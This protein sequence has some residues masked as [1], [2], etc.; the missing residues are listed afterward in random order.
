MQKGRSVVLVSLFFIVFFCL[1]VSAEAYEGDYFLNMYNVSYRLQHGTANMVLVGDSIVANIATPRIQYG[2]IRQWTP[3]RWRGVITTTSTGVTDQGTQT[4]NVPAGT[5]FSSNPGDVLA[6]GSIGWNPVPVNTYNITPDQAFGTTFLGQ[7]VA[8]SSYHVWR[9]VTGVDDWT[10][11]ANLTARFIYLSNLSSPRILL[12]FKLRNNTNLGGITADLNN[13]VKNIYWYDA[14]ATNNLTGTTVTG[15]F[16][17]SS[18]NGNFNETLFP[19]YQPFGTRIFRRDITTGLQVGTLATG[20]FTT[21]N[22]TNSSTPAYSDQGLQR[23]MLANELNTFFIWLG[24]NSAPDEW[25]GNN[26][27]NYQTN[28]EN[29]IRR[30]IQS[31]NNVSANYSVGASEKPFFVLVSTYDTANNNTKF[32]QQEQALYNISRHYNNISGIANLA[33]VAYLG[34]R[35]KLNVTNGSFVTWNITYLVDGT[36]PSYN[37]SNYTALLMWQEVQ[38]ALSTPNGSLSTFNWE[39]T[40]YKIKN[41]TLDTETNYFNNSGVLNSTLRLYN[42]SNALIFY[43]N[44]TGA[45]GL[46]VNANDGNINI[47]LQPNENLTVLYNFNLTEDVARNNSP[48]WFSAVST[49]SKSIASNLTSTINA[50]VIFNVSSCTID[51]ISYT[52]HTSAFTKTYTSSEYNCSSGQVT[53]NVSGLE[54]ASGSNT[55]AISYTAAASSGDSGSGTSSPAVSAGALSSTT[56][57]S[58]IFVS[59]NHR[60]LF[61]VKNQPH[62]LRVNGLTTD[63]IDITV[64]STPQRATLRLGE[65]KKFML[66]DDTS[67]DLMVTLNSIRNDFANLTLRYLNEIPSDPITPEP[68]PSGNETTLVKEKE[69]NSFLIVSVVAFI[70]VILLV[71][72]LLKNRITNGP[73]SHKHVRS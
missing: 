23:W 17:T 46:D 53:L 69:S 7:T 52:S 36:H 60:I 32:V 73:F 19:I 45:G 3:D 72:L 5:S 50:T 27:G 57:P 40:S 55:F 56:T 12:V 62:T 42:V 20:G 71:L 25:N 48:L 31:Y 28:I 15:I 66:D 16:P 22:H 4:Q 65:S 8:A 64:S 2:I 35:D 47:T 70:G 41:R 54:T 30:Y 59:V 51:S 49:T 11:G 34:L 21:H 37:G 26:I 44:F 14:N 13:S 1:R 29:I 39:A 58:N 43:G 68:T 63:S 33:E 18:N 61:S 67:Y 9:N 10:A 6:D 38:K 24:Q